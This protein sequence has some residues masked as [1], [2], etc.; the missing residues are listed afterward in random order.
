[1]SNTEMRGRLKNF[2][3]PLEFWKNDNFKVYDRCSNFADVIRPDEINII[4][5]LEI[6]DEFWKV[7]SLL[8]ELYEKLNKGICIIALQ[9]KRGADTGK[10]GDVTREKPRLYLT[11]ESGVITIEKAKNWKQEGVNP[12]NLKREFKLVAGSKFLP[13]TEWEYKD[14]RPLEMPSPYPKHFS[15]DLN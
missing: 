12:N 11:M 2:G 13:T 8:K 6:H 5:F 7:G 4:D 1:M 15:E 9:K 10:G 14:G 3:Q